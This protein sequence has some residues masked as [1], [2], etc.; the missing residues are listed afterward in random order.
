VIHESSC[1]VGLNKNEP[2]LLAR[3]NGALTDAK[4]NGE[5]NAIVQKW[6]HVPLP[7]QVAQTLD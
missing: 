7:Q 5:L 2:K 6:L 1:R 3:V 4:K